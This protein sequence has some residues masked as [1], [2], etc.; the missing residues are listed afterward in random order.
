MIISMQVNNCNGSMDIGTT[1]SESDRRCYLER[2]NKYMYICIF[3]YINKYIHY[4]Y[5]IP[6]EFVVSHTV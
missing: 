5:S 2:T 6:F 4:C 1:Y 3:I